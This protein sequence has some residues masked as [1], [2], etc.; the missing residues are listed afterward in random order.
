MIEDFRFGDWEWD[1]YAIYLTVSSDLEIEI[2]YVITLGNIPNKK[3]YSNP[4]QVLIKSKYSPP[5]KKHLI[6]TYPTRNH[7]WWRSRLNLHL[8]IPL[9][10]GW[11]CHPVHPVTLCKTK[12]MTILLPAP[13][14]APSVAWQATTHGK[15]IP[16][17]HKVCLPTFNH[18]NQLNVGKYIIHGSYGMGWS[19]NPNHLFLTEIYPRI[20]S[21]SLNKPAAM[22]PFFRFLVSK[23]KIRSLGLLSHQL[24]EMIH[25]KLMTYGQVTRD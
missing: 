13:I 25:G 5:K 16:R 24:Q 12:A 3:Y 21:V 19:S 15:K 2:I 1:W 9:H 17:N 11:D 10:K 22:F 14:L 20:C 8:T 7:L 4:V 18:K 6:D 23:K